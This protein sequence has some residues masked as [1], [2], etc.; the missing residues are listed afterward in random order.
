MYDHRK[1]LVI[2]DLI[3][4]VC[5]CLTMTEYASPYENFE[6]FK[7]IWQSTSANFE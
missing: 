1:L 7:K 3:H 2:C 4:V 5:L 6:D